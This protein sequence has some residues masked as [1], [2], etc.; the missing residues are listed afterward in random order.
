MNRRAHRSNWKERL[1]TIGLISLI[2]GVLALFIFTSY[3]ERWEPGQE[4]RGTVSELHH[5]PRE[6]GPSY[7][8]FSVQLETGQVVSVAGTQYLPYQPGQPVIVRESKSTIRRKQYQ[9]V[10]FVED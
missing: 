3:F 8:L 5:F 9:F 6:Q 1:I 2:G 10:R 7:T 4:L